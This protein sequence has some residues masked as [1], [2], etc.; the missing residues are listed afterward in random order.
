MDF[1]TVFPKAQGK[2][3]IF[4]VVDHLTKF[5]HCFSIFMDY[6]A[7]LIEKLFFRNIF[8]LHGLPKAIVSD[9]DNR[10]MRTF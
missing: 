6:S 1:I 7:L 9:R 2:D 5:S 10:F 8:I 3:G 4:V